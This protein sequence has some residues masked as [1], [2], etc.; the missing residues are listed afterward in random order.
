MGSYT[1]TFSMSTTVCASNY[2]YQGQVYSP[3]FSEPS[4]P[5]SSTTSSQPPSPKPDLKYDFEEEFVSKRPKFANKYEEMLQPLDPVRILPSHQIV[6]HNNKS[7]QL[8]P[9]KTHQSNV[10]KKLQEQFQN[11]ML[12]V[13]S[14]SKQTAEENNVNNKRKADVD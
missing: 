3:A 11:L 2:E 9:K 5:M 6:K 13:C 14:N 10:D 12:L 8:V 4:S 1:E 7:K